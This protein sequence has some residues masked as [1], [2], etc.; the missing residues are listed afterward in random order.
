MPLMLPL[1]A[2]A[3]EAVAAQSKRMYAKRNRAIVVALTLL[4]FTVN[5]MDSLQRIVDI[6]T[7]ECSRK[8]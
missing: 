5:F 3:S 6:Q 8:M 1:P 7:F 4:L 2:C